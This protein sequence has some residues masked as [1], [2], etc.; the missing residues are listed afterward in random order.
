[1]ILIL[2]YPFIAS[3]IW[4]GASHIIKRSDI[5]DVAWGANASLLAFL[6][7]IITQPDFSDPQTIILLLIF[8]WGLR[9]SYYITKRLLSKQED[10]RYAKYRKEWGSAFLLKSYIFFF[11]G[12]SLLIAI[13]AIA[14]Y[15]V[16]HF[17]G[18]LSWTLFHFLGLFVW[19]VGFLFESISDKQLKD[20][21]SNSKNKGKLMT[22]GL[23]KYS[24]HPN[25]FGEAT[26]WWG[27]FLM[28]I[29]FPW[30]WISII[31]PLTITFFLLKVTGVPLAE[32]SLE[33]HPDFEKYKRKTSIFLPLPPRD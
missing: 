13:I 9:L 5:V 23:W 29:P 25:Y 15:F 32:K 4:Y 8:L 14:P 12:Q 26:M 21:L 22:Q 31:S 6:A 19:I 16:V 7:Y 11:L 1:M 17:E 27:V 3:L 30:G 24:R 20:F 33:S 2:F 28:L 18:S 10:P